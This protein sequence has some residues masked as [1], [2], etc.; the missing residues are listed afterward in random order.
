[1]I[2]FKTFF[3][4]LALV[5]SSAVM[6]QVGT[7][8]TQQKEIPFVKVTKNDKSVYIGQIIKDDGRE[9]LLRTTTIG[10]VYI[11][12]SDIK[13]IQPVDKLQ[14]TYSGDYREE[15][16]FKSRYYFTNNALPLEKGDNYGLI[17][18]YGPEVHVAVS[19]RLSVGVMAT[20]IAS[21]I[22][23]A[24]KYAIPTQN[25]KVN[26]SLGTIM[27]SSGY[28]NKAKGWG[29]LHWGSI[30]FGKAGKNMTLSS[31]VGYVDLGFTTYNNPVNYLKVASVSSVAGIF[32][33]GD[34]ASF[35]FDSMITLSERRNYLNNDYF[36][37]GFVDSDG[38]PADI[39]TVYN[40]GTEFSSFFMPG[41]R[42]QK[43]DRT[44]FQVALAGV[45]QYST[46][47]FRYSS[48]VSNSRAFPV[49]MC[50]W[51]FKF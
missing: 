6:A 41:M 49:P 43:S 21:P 32:P 30:T 3:L 14:A 16:P 26:L 7:D 50:S 15:G 46:I 12:K 22:G 11:S 27:F 35:I 40:S 20:W 24:L 18:L 4:C 48:Q 19:D 23:I 17:H 2:N 10:D 25:E 39:P 29:G 45:I 36:G 9:V 13:S 8:S 5:A 1:M 31:G 37:G 51:F 38:N 47:G 33:V 28:L 42:F 34:R 44:A